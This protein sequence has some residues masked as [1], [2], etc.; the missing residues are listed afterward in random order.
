MTN[1]HFSAEWL[2]LREPFDAAAR[3]VAASSLNLSAA[4]EPIRPSDG[5]PWRMVDL[6]CGAGANVRW[7]APVLGGAQEWLVVDHDEALLRGWADQLP[8]AGVGQGG[9]AWPW[10]RH[11]GPGFDAVIARQPTDLLSGLSALP[12]HAADLVTASALL[13]LV[14]PDWLADL[15]ACAAAARVPLLMTLNVDG[16][17][18]WFPVDLDDHRVARAFARHQRRDKGLGPALGAR[19]VPVLRSLLKQAG[20]QMVCANSP[21][22]IDGR[23]GA[24]A[25]TL[26]RA[27]IDGMARA[28]VEH[29][30]KSKAWVHAWRERRHQMAP[31]AQLTVGH[32]DVL[33]LPG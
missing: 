5:R 10:L 1:A 11:A 28:A 20:Y 19:A 2:R 23:A 8:E 22:Q 14:G 12:W 31:R 33:A 32:I 17:H 6:G 9:S 4:L 21:W 27:M 24:E 30:P 7:L 26:Q 25:L 15:V 29:S 3:R 16:R 13:D 18:D